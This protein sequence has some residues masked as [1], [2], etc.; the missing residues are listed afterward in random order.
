LAPLT[1]VPTTVGEF[2][3]V[4]LFWQKGDAFV[5]CGMPPS[6]STPLAT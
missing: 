3:S 4:I 2:M 6:I 1:S 5:D